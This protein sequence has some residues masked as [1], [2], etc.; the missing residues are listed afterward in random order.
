MMLKILSLGA[1]VQ[2]STMALMYAQHE[3]SPMPDCAIFADTKQEPLAVYDWLRWLE[4]RLPFP[5]HQ[6]SKGDLWASATRVRHTR[7]GKRTYIETAIPAFMQDGESE[8]KGLRHCTTDFKIDPINKKVRELLGKKRVMKRD[9]VLA[10]MLIGISLD[11]AMRMKPNRL[12]WIESKWPLIDA[13]M[14]R[15]DCLVWMERNGYPAP[16]RSACTFCPYR[17]DAQWLALTPAEFDDT[18][19]KELELQAAFRVT[20]SI[21]SIPYLHESRQPLRTVKFDPLTR[22]KMGAEQTNLF[23]NECEGIC[24]V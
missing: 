13:G 22:R 9:G 20:T 7:K 11:E 23:I 10:Q 21:R 4:G 15:A 5:I 6:V 14:S 8:G 1:G 3:L 16:P 12:D 2:S 19:I 17:S 24:G 18:C